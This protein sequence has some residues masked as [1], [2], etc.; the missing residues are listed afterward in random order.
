M[1]SLT[2]TDAAVRLGADL[3]L[4]GVQLAVADGER[5]AIVGPSGSGK[6]T[7]LRAIAGFERIT[8]GEIRLGAEIAATGT[9]HLAPHRRRIGYVAQD[10]ALFPHLTARRNIAFGLRG[11]VRGERTGAVA[12]AATLA[13]I[14]PELLDRYPHEISGGQQQRVSLARAL[15]PH[16]RVLLLDEPFSALDTE[17]RTQ[18]RA[19]VVEAL[20]RA[21]VTSVLVTHDPEEAL[22]FG[23]AVAV[24]DGGRLQ[25]A[26]P[27]ADVFARPVSAAVARLLGDIVLLAGEKTAAGGFRCPIGTLA[28]DADFSGGASTSVAMVR[29]TQLRLTTDAEAAPA[30]VTAIA[31]V[32]ATATATLACADGT[33]VAVPL[34]AIGTPIPAL[35]DEVRVTVDG[36]AV[37]YAA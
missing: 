7:L 36:G 20:T 15:A 6:S 28:I 21:Q 22:A 24:L 27:C 3:V 19:Q 17:L 31:L 5:L 37:L 34:R 9:R 2:V 1:T 26:G 30:R 29:P 16:P 25:Q 10:G 4:D 8:G 14:E 35:G 23:Q 12:A 33:T 11:S 18:V 32:G 13:G